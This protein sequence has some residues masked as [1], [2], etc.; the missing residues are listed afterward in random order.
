MK[1]LID[2]DFLIALHFPGEVKHR[3]ANEIAAERLLTAE[4]AYSHL[5]LQECATVI[6]RKYSQR[7]ARQVSSI[8]RENSNGVL[9]VSKQQMLEVWQLFDQQQGAKTSY[10]D[11]SNVVLARQLGCQIVSFDQFYQQFADVRLAL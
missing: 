1:Y 3:Q 2:T 10:I 8:L 6:S 9:F 7:A 5:V 11:C 4:S